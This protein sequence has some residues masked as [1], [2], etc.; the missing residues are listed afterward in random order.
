MFLHAYKL[1]FELD[2][3]Y[4]VIAPLDQDWHALM[5]LLQQQ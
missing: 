3:A 4:E 1:S 2:K 5:A